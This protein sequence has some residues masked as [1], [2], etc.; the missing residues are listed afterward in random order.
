MNNIKVGNRFEFNSPTPTP[1]G[2][3]FEIEVININDFRE[4]S[5]RY[6]IDIC[7]QN[8]LWSCN[9]KFVGDDFFEIN[10]EKMTK[11]C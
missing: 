10:K 8:G 1:Y 9:I 7:D 6:G 4:P 3:R 5:M 2:K 11:I